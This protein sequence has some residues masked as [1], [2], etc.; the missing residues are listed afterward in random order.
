MKRE[1]DIVVSD[2]KRIYDSSVQLWFK[3]AHGD[4]DML[5]CG[6]PGIPGVPGGNEKMNYEFSYISGAIGA[7]QDIIKRKFKDKLK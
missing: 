5:H 1:R 6:H 4:N 7:L 2:E 3:Y